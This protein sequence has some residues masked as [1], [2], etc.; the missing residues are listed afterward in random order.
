[1][2]RRAAMI[3]AVMLVVGVPCAAESFSLMTW[4]VQFYPE[5]ASYPKRGVWFTTTIERI[6]ADILCIQEI[7]GT[8]QDF[9]QREYVTSGFLNNT[10]DSMDNALFFSSDVESCDAPDPSGFLHP[11]Q[12]AWFQ[13]AGLEAFVIT[14]HLEWKNASCRAKER[15]LLAE[16]VAN[17]LAIHPDLIIAGDFN[18]TE[19]E[20]DSIAELAAAT[21]LVWI[22][23]D[24]YTPD[25][26]ASW[27][28]NFRV[29]ALN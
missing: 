2:K 10:S 13:I 28:D 24:N 12:C 1:M 26:E 15:A 21:G 22:E 17:Y 27:F 9:I 29:T 16:V 3:L 19:S 14:F 8:A 23:P 11:A 20:G 5:D 18:T 25:C 7:N 6:D 4:N